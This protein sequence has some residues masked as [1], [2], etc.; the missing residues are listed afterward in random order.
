MTCALHEQYLHG[1]PLVIEIALSCV[2]LVLLV[3][4]LYSCVTCKS[5]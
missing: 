2:Y 4:F 3:Y 1:D 5:K